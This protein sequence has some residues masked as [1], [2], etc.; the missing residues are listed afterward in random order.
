MEDLLQDVRRG[1]L[2]SVQVRIG[3]DRSLLNAR[4]DYWPYTALACA[5]GYGHLHIARHLLSEGA[6]VND[7]D[8]SGSPALRQACTGGNRAMVELL[9][10]AGADAVTPNEGGNTP[11]LCAAMRRHVG[12]VRALLAHGCGDIDA[13]NRDGGTAL[14]WACYAGHADVVLLL[15]DAGADSRIA[16]TQG[17]TPLD[18][19][20]ERT[21]EG[22]V[23]VLEVSTHTNQYYTN[24]AFNARVS[25]HI[26]S[27]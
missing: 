3:A 13:R 23:A 15:L 7:G 1:D 8:G 25:A 22:C 6:Q 18:I 9:L 5:A 19:A 10:E 4:G 12:I 20:L 26:S 21:H 11:L 27:K 2:A 24:D 17:R 14:W 16:E